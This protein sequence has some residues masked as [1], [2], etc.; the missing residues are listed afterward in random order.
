MRNLLALI[1]IFVMF[2]VVAAAGPAPQPAPAAP[3]AKGKSRK[4]AA[5]AKRPAAKSAKSATS[6][7]KAKGRTTTSRRSRRSRT[8]VQSGPSSDRIREIQEALARGGFYKHGPTGRWDAQTVAALSSFQAANGIEVTGKLG[9]WTL[10]KLEE[11]Q[12]LPGNSELT[13]AAQ[14]GSINSQ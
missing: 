8:V 2:A 10:K 13:E 12:G 9:A 5:A 11:S 14:S 7:R 4:P 1:S 3:A 6:G